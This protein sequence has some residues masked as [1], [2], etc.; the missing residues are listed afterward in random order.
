M[1][2]K[3]EKKNIWQI[4]NQEELDQIYDYGE[5]YKSFFRQF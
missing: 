2:L 1:D 3:Y 4:S 5:R